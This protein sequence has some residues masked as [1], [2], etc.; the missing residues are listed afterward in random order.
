MLIRRLVVVGLVGFVSLA[1]SFATAEEAVAPGASSIAIDGVSF[2]DAVDSF[3]DRFRLDFGTGENARFSTLGST[4][5]PVVAGN[6]RSYELSLVARAAAGLDVAFAQRGGLGFN[7][8]GDVASQRRASELRLGRGLRNVRRD[9]PSA[10]PKWYIF[11]ASEDE[12]LIWQPGGRND[13]GSSASGLAL[14]DRVEVGDMQAGITYEQNGIQASL[15][16]VQREVSVRA[17]NRSIS[18]DEDFTGL[19]LT[20]RHP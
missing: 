11:A 7:E 8:H 19:T 6:E 4:R 14:Q 2:T 12:A 20:M 13:F 5:R 1:A 3:A 16:Y 10:T 9:Q 15:A 18:Q 17:G